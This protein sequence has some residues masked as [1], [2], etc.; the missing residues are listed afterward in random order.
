VAGHTALFFCGSMVATSST[1]ITK[2]A[3]I[4]SKSWRRLRGSHVWNSNVWSASALADLNPLTSSVWLSATV[5]LL[6]AARVGHLDKSLLMS[7]LALGALCQRLFAV[8]EQLTLCCTGPAQEALV[9]AV[10]GKVELVIFSSVA[11][12]QGELD[13]VEV[14]LLGSALFALVAVSGFSLLISAVASPKHE[15]VF[16]SLRASLGVI[17][18]AAG[19]A[20]F[21][22]LLITTS[23]CTE[24]RGKHRCADATGKALQ[25]SQWCSGVMLV[26]YCLWLWR[27]GP[28]QGSR[29]VAI[30]SGN[31]RRRAAVVL[32]CWVMLLCAAAGPVSKAVLTALKSDFRFD[33]QARSLVAAIVIPAAVNLGDLTSAALHAWRGRIDA[34]VRVSVGSTVQVVLCLLPTAV[35]GAAKHG[36][37]L[38][39]TST[40]THAAALLLASIVSTRALGDRGHT[41]AVKGASLL[42]AYAMLA[43]F[44]WAEGQR[45]TS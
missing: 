29:E 3:D 38:S 37:A 41:S 28:T 31:E 30:G 36:V 44:F 43:A 13:L 9:L 35:F 12:Q 17:N 42:G 21:P 15:V 26:M 23:T 19:G 32:L 16:D 11:L 34:A 1:P 20:V 27:C 7:L 14:A 40:M 25:L 4:V 24:R 22:A 10:L 45:T 33:Q 39:L 18:L 6:L 8:V 5:L 2:L